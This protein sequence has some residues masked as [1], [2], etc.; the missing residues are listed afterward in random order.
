VIKKISLLLSL[1]TLIQAELIDL[2]T[3]GTT[4]EIAEENMHTLMLKNLKNL[5][6]KKLMNGLK[7]KMENAKTSHVNVPPCDTDFQHTTHSKHQYGEDVYNL[8]G[9]IVHKKGDIVE[10]KPIVDVS[11][12]YCVLNF[13]H[14]DMFKAQYDFLQSHHKCHFLVS[15]TDIFEFKKQF[16]EPSA[17][18]FSEYLRDDYNVTCTP[19]VVELKY[20]QSQN[21]Y[22]SVQRWQK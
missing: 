12:T 8:K 1:S 5:D 13:T 7:E 3:R 20:T 17:S 6:T 21:Q 22:Y 18:I 9:K 19:S 2:G 15:G 10:H 4:Y 16:N 11:E 14:K